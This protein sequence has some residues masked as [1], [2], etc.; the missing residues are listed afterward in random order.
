VLTRDQNDRLTRVGPGTPLGTLLRRYWWPVA[1]VSEMLDRPTKPVRLM[2]EDLVLFK[3]R[4]GQ[5]GLLGQRC[6]HRSVDL[7][8]GIPEENGLRCPY[9]G[10]LYDAT[11]Q[12]LEQPAEEPESTFYQRVQVPA[13][14]VEELGGLIFAYLGPGPT[15]LLP[16]W[17]LYAMDNV[18]RDVGATMI[19]CNWLQCMENSVDPTHAEYLHGWYFKYC[20]EE[21][22]RQGRPHPDW[23]VA[24]VTPFLKHH[25]KID[26]H[27]YKYGIIKKR[28]LEGDAET[29]DDWRM[30]HPLVFP[31]KV[32]IPVL[33]TGA[34]FQIRV[35]V[36]DTTTWHLEYE[37]FFPPDGVQA[38]RQDVVPLYDLPLQNDLGQFA[39]YILAQDMLAWPAQGPIVDRSV[40]RLAGSDR[41]LLLYRRM[42][43][44]EIEKCERGEDPINVFRDPSDNEYIPLAT[45][46]YGHNMTLNM[47]AVRRKPSGNFSP[48][49]E[50]LEEM[51]GER[52][53]VTR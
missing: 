23:T 44:E 6:A 34:A 5:Y 42:L 29:T 45:H 17:D 35:P 30:G 46:D 37:V 11:G 31:D 1:G 47:D 32:R 25:V 3:D 43:L 18:V 19:P 51:Y 52:T 41:G 40:E 20:L 8:Y 15:P 4:R 50:L 7:K 48:I 14:P 26:F 22:E 13:Y 10:W 39:D 53:P 27:R 38:P 28:L 21:L 36:D 24:Q 12:C 2:G 49:T 16:R 9:H 33:G